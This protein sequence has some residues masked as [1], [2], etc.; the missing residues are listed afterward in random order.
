MGARKRTDL[1]VSVT[2]WKDVTGHLHTDPHRAGL[3][4]Y[5]SKTTSCTLLPGITPLATKHL[6]RL[7]FS[8]DITLWRWFYTSPTPS[9]LDFT[10]SFCFLRQKHIIHHCLLWGCMPK[11]QCFP[12][13]HD[14]HAPR[15]PKTVGTHTSQ[16]DTASPSSPWGI[17]GDLH[18]NWV[19]VVFLLQLSR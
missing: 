13:D 7:S 18:L 19:A 17:L 9:S 15:N 16:L 5:K 14:A 10:F 4:R 1:L 11:K 3:C 2:A 6:L 12:P 8:F